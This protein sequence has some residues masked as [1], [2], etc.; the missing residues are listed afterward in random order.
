M[1]FMTQQRRWGMLK[2]EPDYLAVAAAINQVALY[3]EAADL[4]RHAAAGG[5][6]RSS[7]LIDGKLW[8]GSDPAAYAAS[9]SASATPAA[10]L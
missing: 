7:V 1:W 9:F 2:D 5:R 4:T 6:M 8:D 10:I 3:R